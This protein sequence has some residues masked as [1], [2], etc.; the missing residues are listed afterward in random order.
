MKHEKHIA[1]ILKIKLRQLGSTLDI[2]QESN[3][4]DEQ[5]AYL[6]IEDRYIE[7]IR[8]REEEE[9]WV[10]FCYDGVFLSST[11]ALD[12]TEITNI[13]F[14]F[15][16]LKISIRDFLNTYSPSSIDISN[17]T[18]DDEILFELFWFSF[19]QPSKYD[20]HDSPKWLIVREFAKT[21]QSIAKA[22]RLYPYRSLD[23]LC[24]TLDRKLNT[25]SFPHIWVSSQEKDTP[26][27]S[28]AYANN[29]TTSFE[30]T[31]KE[32]E[33]KFKEIIQ[34]KT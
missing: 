27:F 18:N 2:L 4:I 12:I 22:K 3:E 11:H 6:S 34:S 33:N 5:V 30:G 16:E 31:A 7:I 13:I 21:I 19:L 8:V 9:I 17:F 1:D 26:F 28:I 10:S 14:E 15:L 20:A 24:F 32:I 23:S 25:G 29:L